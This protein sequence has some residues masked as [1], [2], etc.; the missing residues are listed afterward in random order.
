MEPA[1]ADSAGGGLFGQLS[2]IFI[3]ILINA[4]YAASEMALVS[5]DDGDLKEN[6]QKGDKK[7]KR[8]LELM[9]DPSRFLSTIQICITLAGFFNSASAATGISVVIGQKLQA[10]GMP[11]AYRLSTVV[12]TI[13]LSF[14]TIVFGELVPKR[15]ALQNPESFSYKAVTILWW[16]SK[17]LKPFVSL[18][19]GITNG[20]MRLMGIEVSESEERVTMSD[21]K[22]IIQVGQSQGL[23]NTVEEEMINSIISFDDKTAE[24]IMT[25]RTE[26]FAIDIN[27]PYEEYLD[28]L[29]SVRYSRIP[30]YDDDID[31][32]IG[33]LYI[34]DYLQAA[35]E[36][37]F[38]E[39][40]IRKILR[41]AYFVP[42]RKNINELFNEMRKENFHFAV[43]IDEYGGFS[44]IVTMEDLIEEIVGD[45]DDEYDDDEPEI[46]KINSKTWYAKGSLSIKELNANIGSNI[47]EEAEDYDT[48]GGL[49]FYLMGRI[50]EDS[51]K[52]FIEYE[53]IDFMIDQIEN[54]KIV[55]VRI[56][57]DHEEAL[58]LEAERLNKGDKENG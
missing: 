7:A 35:Y 19:S 57:Y 4:F 10:L 17:I 37:S 38:E 43:L 24:E 52:P 5:V 54:K 44:G 29:L 15:L 14:V 58:R 21:I 39:V 32:I 8:I 42:E 51:E 11:S 50:P 6:A 1:Q 18:L 55:W 20:I 2:V 36:H 22:S 9:S 3:L 30:V 31:N 16:S 56:E 47:D 26:V 48:L 49:L 33:V 23:I 28:E 41:P 53:N 46:K 45:I 40:K 12:F 27:D 13:I 25:P 34:K